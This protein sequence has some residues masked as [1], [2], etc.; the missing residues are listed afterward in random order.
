[1]VRS[2][3]YGFVQSVNRP[4]VRG[5]TGRC[6]CLTKATAGWGSDCR[7]T[8]HTQLVAGA[9]RHRPGRDVRSPI[10]VS[11]RTMDDTSVR[12]LVRASA[13]SY[14][15]RQGRRCSLPG[16]SVAP[17]NHLARPEPIVE[18]CG[19]GHGIRSATPIV[20][21]MAG[22]PDGFR[23]KGCPHPTLQTHYSRLGD[24]LVG[25]TRC[26]YG[27]PETAGSPWCPEGPRRPDRHR[28]A[29]Q[30][31]RLIVVTIVLSSSRL[32]IRLAVPTSVSL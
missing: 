28:P 2:Y 10:Y 23:D 9:S 22:E 11:A 7:F 25:T 20:A 17:A 31:A 18:A 32:P 1:M 30:I 27:A 3:W 21:G 5:D 8:A 4:L 16:S 15:A 12:L 26:G 19:R 14:I 24:G 6:I 13:A 29:S